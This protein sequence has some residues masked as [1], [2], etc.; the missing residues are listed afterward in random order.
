M[1]KNSIFVRIVSISLFLSIFLYLT[2]YVYPGDAQKREKVVIIG[3]DGADYELAKKYLEKNKLPNL[4]KLMETG[5]FTSTMPTNPPQTPVSWA[6]FCTGLDPGENGVFDFL[7]R[8][9]G[10]Y[11][12]DYVLMEESEIPFL[13]GKKNII[14]IP[15]II[16]IISFIIFLI[17]FRLFKIKISNSLILSIIFSLLFTSSFAYFVSIFLPQKRPIAIN[18]MKGK[19]FFKLASENGIRVK[20]FHVPDTFPPPELGDGKLLSGLGV[21]DMR[22]TIGYPSLYTTDEELLKKANEFSVRIVKLDK[23]KTSWSTD[24]MGPRNKLFYDYSNPEK[25]AKKGIKKDIT[26]PLSLEYLP[27]KKRI[28]IGT[29]GRY[30]EI[31]LHQWS[32]WFEI[33]FKFNRFI[34]IWGLGRFYL[35]QIEPEFKIYLS[36]IHLHPKRI[37]IPISYPKNFSSYLADKIGLYKTMGWASDTW[38]IT[39]DLCDE[40]HFV[41]DMNFTIDKEEEKMIKM[42]EEK[43]WDLF[44]YVY[45]FTDRVQHVMWRLIDEKHPVYKKDVAEKWGNQIEMAY[46]RMDQIA[47]KVM[48]RID[49]NTL[50]MVISD[51][52]FASFRRGINYNTW[53]R[54]NGFFVERP[55]DRDRLRTLEDLWGEERRIFPY[56]DWSKTKAYALGLGGIY[57]NLKGREP[58]GIVQTGEEYERV[59]D[60]I[61]RGL[62]SYVDPVTGEHPVYK[63]YRR[64]KIY[65]N[66]D[67]SIVPDLRITNNKGYRVSWQT[68]LGGAPSEIVEDNTKTWSADHCSMEPTQIPGIFFSNKKMNSNNIHIIDFYRTICKIYGIDLPSE[69]RGKNFYQYKRN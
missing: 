56:V 24:V 8:V 52:G 15:S 57:I 14:I 2:S 51:H 42:L 12:P 7:K 19:T 22:G 46:Q 55:Y 44:I 30:E 17:I 64:D 41:T 69:I 48:E 32:D 25:M 29:A 1:R 38:S 6:S 27:E 11:L 60:E 20:V 34:S 5:T 31:G 13:F 28:K 68:S 26:V 21:P 4:K 59:C 54:E 53:L 35:E 16:F 45:M 49:K 65:R 58:Q 33:E 47:G 10:T 66:F 9:P 39:S 67:S 40:N 37:T 3:F 43:D 63:V 36:P 23:G 62:E 18:H 61:K 50:L